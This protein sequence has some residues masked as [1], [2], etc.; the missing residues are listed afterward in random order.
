MRTKQTAITN[1]VLLLVAGITG[2][3]SAQEEAAAPA[4]PEENQVVI[5]GSRLA[6]R[7][8]LAP[9]PVTVVDAT[10]LKVSGT[11]NLE[12]LLND[13]PQFTA[14]QLNSP[15]ANTVQA[16][17][18][19]GTS[20]LN[21][22][23][24]GPTRN[25]VL[26]NGR[27][28]AITGPDFTTDI[29][30]IPTALVK[31]I[32][33]VTGGSSAVYGSDAIS[34]VVNFILR[35]NFEGAEINVQGNWDQ[36]TR[37]PTKSID[38]TVG[39]NFDNKKGNAVLSVN[40]QDRQGMT[41]GDL[42]G[43]ATPSLGDGCVTSASWSATRPGT[44]LS[45]PSGQTCL[46]AGG[47]PGLVYSGSST[48]PTGRI[49]NLPLYG[50]S[51]S[52]AALDAAMAAAGLQGMSTLGA[53]F[54]ST[55]KVVR[56]YTTADAYDLGPLS[57][58][59]TPQKR[60]V[61]NAFAHYNF[62]EYATGYTEIHFSN[63][64]ANVQ[65]A[66][67]GAGANFLV[68]TNNPYLSPQMQE[69]L[70]QLDLKE[71]GT[72][73][74]TNGSQ[75]LTTT[76]GDGLAVL[77]LNRRLT[78]IGTRFAATDHSTFRIALGLK[79]KLN[80]VSEHYLTDL[81]YDMYYTNSR[82]TESQFQSGSISLSRYQNAILAQGGAAPVLNPFGQN[83]TP[84]AASAV[85]IASNSAITAEQQGLAAN[86]TGKLLELPAGPVDFSAGAEHRHAYSRYSPDAYLSSG[87]VS[88][89]NAARATQGES[90]V[91]EVFG[92]ARV[93]LLS[94][95]PFAK[96]LSLSGAFRRSAYDI[97]SVG[98]VWTNSVGTEWT[99]VDSLTFRAQKQ[100]SIRAPNVGELF[101][102]QG[103]NGPT[104]TDP[105][106]S[107]QPAAQQTAAVKALCVATGVPANLVFD[108][109]VQPTNFL[110]QIVGGN[111]N[112][113]AETSH[114]TTFGAVFAP[115]MVPGLQMSVD[116][117]KI[118]LDDAISTLGGG[119]IQSVLNLCY[120]TIQNANSVYCKAINRDPVT[121]QI[122]AP[123]Y[124]MTTAANI[125]GI[126]T[127]G[128]DLAGHYGF[129]SS[130]GLMGAD[131]RW[132]IDTNWTYVKEL[133]FTPI[134]DLPSITNQCVGS[135]G[136]TCG[137]PVPKWKGTA[138][139]TMNTGKLMLS[140]RA[141]YIGPVT[142]DTYVLPST[143]GGSAPALDSLTNP[144]I[145]GYTY[146]DLTAG[147]DFTKSVSLTAGIRN[148]LDKDPPV[149]GSSQLPA[150][151][152]IAATYDP[153]GRNLFFSLNVKL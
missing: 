43:Y 100:K 54:D 15:T 96:N 101:G 27:R 58:V 51:G 49:G 116:Y 36:P 143:S 149:L 91:K 11:Q 65:I 8:F 137:Q 119:G 20:T 30:T 114:T 106:S 124:V 39:G 6:N 59:V 139:L 78:D 25:L 104:A 63:N 16:G 76:P 138:R 9:T 113:K 28:Y 153:L 123:T 75:T 4:K 35:D 136:Q 67:A 72:T 10:E 128:Y 73:R 94:D 68:N 131:T 62:N 17:Q 144:K 33:T 69:V 45:V 132:N 19:S 121:G 108:P 111:P 127:E 26:V 3:A 140:A 1:A 74:V 64:T 88:G 146:L 55:G 102:G 21:L 97:E 142:V 61:A 103:T 84:A 90:T 122:A 7:G 107:R 40:F 98:T 133:T 79:G 60:W 57:Y 117:Y 130:W 5:T 18:P 2:A 50:S 109:S 110:T 52:N 152:T 151:N 31:R 47:R 92:E 147:Y 126:K 82:T 53:V 129:R 93:P 148:V 46:S 95:K 23:N 13:T 85:S 71:S 29:N 89:W 141:R 145:K 32:E 34:G 70:R 37:T 118:T 12:N 112:L 48:V 83:I 56:P 134:Q 44:P 80:D 22:R 86:L 66:P 120:N 135:F 77:N 115:K 38:L 14:N 125:G 87:D 105:C 81:K 41:R 99:P 42:G 24:L 150:N